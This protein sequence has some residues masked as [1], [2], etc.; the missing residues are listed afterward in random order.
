MILYD[1]VCSGDGMDRRL[2]QATARAMVPRRDTDMVLAMARRA[3]MRP[4]TVRDMDRA[5]TGLTTTVMTV[6]A[7]ARMALQVRLSVASSVA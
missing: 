5:T 4:V 7:A 2:A 6:A 1:T 3:A